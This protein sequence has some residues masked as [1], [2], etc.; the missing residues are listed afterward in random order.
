PGGVPPQPQGWEGPPGAP[1]QRPSNGL[2][3]AA[4]IVGIIALLI[5]F[6]PF[7]GFLGIV[8]L[9]LGFLGLS[10][11]K[12]PGVP[13]KG[14]A[15]TG[16]VTGGLGV[17]GA[18]AWIVVGGL[19]L[20]SLS[21]NADDFVRELEQAASE[22]EPTAD[23]QPRQAEQPQTGG[24]TT[25]VFDLAVGDCFHDRPDLQG[26]IGDVEVVSCDQPHD[27]EV[28]ALLNYPAGA[29][30]PYP[31]QEAVQ[32]WAEENCQ[33]SAFQAYVGMDYASSRYYTT[34][35]S[36]TADTWEQGDRE[37]VCYLY[38]PDEQV[39]GSARGSGQ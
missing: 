20:G 9:V 31:G 19:I 36:P 17:L 28:F 35:L 6:I 37:V 11:A 18:I 29:T 25:S 38:V 13:G 33:G 10:R 16:L 15:I 24:T 26:P 2:A 34:Y 14:M 30:D 3:I 5:A 32:N 39:T 4:L 23:D 1:P 22:F 8:A 21:R 12:R 27:N 7:A